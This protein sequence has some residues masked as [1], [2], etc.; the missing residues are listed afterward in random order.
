MIPL[1]QLPTLI[2]RY[3]AHF[4]DFFKPSEHAHFKEYL[5][6]LLVG[7]NKTVS[8]I[9]RLFL[10]DGKPDQ[11]T[12]N[13]FLTQS[14]WSFRQLNALR[15]KWMQECEQTRFKT[16]PLQSGGVLVL[17]DTL[18]KHVGRHFEHIAYLYDH[19]EKR[20]VWAHNLVNLLYSDQQTE[21]PIDF[22]LWRPAQAD[23]LEQALSLS[24]V[25]ISEKRR[26]ALQVKSPGKWRSYLVQLAGGHQ[27]KDSVQLAYQS[28]LTLAK[29]LLERF[30][31]DWPE[32]DLPVT[33]D[34]WYASAWFCKWIDAQ[35]K[36]YVATLKSDLQVLNEENRLLPLSEWAAQ[37]RAKALANPQQSPFK[38]LSIHYRGTQQTAYV[39]CQSR[40]LKGFG[41]LR[42]VVR[43]HNKELEGEPLFY[44]S[45]QLHWNENTICQIARHRWPVE[46][47][48]QE[49][50]RQG[51]E[52][53]RL[54]DFGA[55]E[56][57][58]ALV[59]MLYSMLQRACSDAQLKGQLHASL[60]QE[61]QGCLPQWR[62]VFVASALLALFHW[63]A[64]Q[65]QDGKP[66]DEV[67]NPICQAI[68]H[69]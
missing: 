19:V 34:S 49:G 44:A 52:Q 32:L 11:S 42:I 16:R 60:K 24:G 58:V 10:M 37:L 64:A 12:L 55:T 61:V 57:H 51:L 4:S 17:D 33:F 6:G 30:Y 18:L 62:R 20:Y 40:F 8:G 15:V 31:A 3:A 68:L 27:D 28:K 53:Y 50:K 47:Y 59:A 7:D 36:A 21:Y 39:L 5:S 22:S 9:S 2:E 13:R 23:F 65:V 48:H 1:V 25:P 67:F 56:K 38:P 46:V 45:N 41:R 26:E 66:I 69:H 63:A 54:R 14:E 43:Y 35:G 29:L